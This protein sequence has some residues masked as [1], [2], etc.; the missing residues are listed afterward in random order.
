MIAV[1]LLRKDTVTDKGEGEVYYIGKKKGVINCNV[2]SSPKLQDHQVII[3]S[4]EAAIDNIF[5]QYGDDYHITKAK[6]EL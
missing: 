2:W 4:G 5:R 3:A 6:E 1:F